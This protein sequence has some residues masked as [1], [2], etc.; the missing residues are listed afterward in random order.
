MIVL[1]LFGDQFDNAQRLSE[2]GYGKRFETYHFS[3]Q[4]LL[5]AVETLINDKQ[6]K[7]QLSVA[8]KRIATDQSKEKACMKIETV[9][10]KYSKNK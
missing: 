2:K 8:S 6:L 1:P 7:E 3:E 10:E 9:A 4:E 5:D